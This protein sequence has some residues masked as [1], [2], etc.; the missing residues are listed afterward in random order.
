MNDLIKLSNRAE[1]LGYSILI[2]P[3]VRLTGDNNNRWFRVFVGNLVSSSLGP[4]IGEGSTLSESCIKANQ[5]LTSESSIN[6]Y[7]CYEKGVE[8][9]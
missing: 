9:A 5:W 8:V 6:N 2:N 4:C 1:R 7:F 3:S